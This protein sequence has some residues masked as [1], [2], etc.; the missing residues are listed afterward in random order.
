MFPAMLVQEAKSALSLL[1]VAL[2]YSGSSSE[3]GSS[4]TTKDAIA[5]YLDRLC[6]SVVTLDLNSLRR[7][8]SK[9]AAADFAMNVVYGNGGEDGTAQGFFETF[10]IPHFGPSVLASAIGMDK[11]IFLALIEAWGFPVPKGC[12]VE[13]L[14]QNGFPAWVETE[15]AFVV[16]PINEGDSLGIK[17]VHGRDRLSSVLNTI[18]LSDRWRWRLEEFVVG[19]FG[20]VAVLDLFGELVV[21]DVVVFDLPQGFEFYDDRLKLHQ[22]EER[23][24]PRVLSGHVATQIAEDAKKLY[25]HFHCKGIVRYDFI[26]GQNG[27]VYLETNTIPGFYPGSNAATCFE[28]YVSFEDLMAVTIYAQLAERPSQR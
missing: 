14:F 23:A 26:S 20:T 21:G 13:T 1:N 17:I 9:I 11:E 8:V 22:V 2:I 7:D 24:A 4:I 5:P 25:R 16:K 27:H 19:P 3:R 28:K 15:N 18:P 6:N 10:G 12:N